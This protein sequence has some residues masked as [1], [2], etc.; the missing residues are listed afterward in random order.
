MFC[1]ISGIH[2]D[3]GGFNSQRTTSG[4]VTVTERY[5]VLVIIINPFLK[6]CVII[7]AKHYEMAIKRRFVQAKIDKFT[8]LSEQKIIKLCCVYYHNFKLNI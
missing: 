3:I 2:L 4:K 6:H 7:K 8:H 1:D 5:Y